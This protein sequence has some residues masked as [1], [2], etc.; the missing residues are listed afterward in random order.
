M[1]ISM[2]TK[3]DSIKHAKGH[4]AALCGFDPSK[5]EEMPDLKVYGMDAILLEDKDV[6]EEV[7]KDILNRIEAQKGFKV[8]TAKGEMQFAIGPFM[9][10]F[11]CWIID[12]K[13]GITIR[14]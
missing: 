2:T 1:A 8:Q 3:F 5:A 13:T 6:S 10:G 11:D 4:L 14:I 12:P 7:K 9:D